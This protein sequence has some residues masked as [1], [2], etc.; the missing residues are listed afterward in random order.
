MIIEKTTTLVRKLLK[1]FLPLLII[2]ILILVVFYHNYLNSLI[3]K[4][5]I[6]DF[7]VK[8]TRI[9]NYKD[10]QHRLNTIHDETISCI[11]IIDT[12]AKVIVTDLLYDKNIDLIKQYIQLTLKSRDDKIYND[13]INEFLIKP[14]FKDN[15]ITSFVVADY[16][17]SLNKKLA[18]TNQTFI[19]I[20]LIVTLILFISIVFAIIFS[21][22][23]VNPIKE[24]IEGIK[25]ISEGDSSYRIHVSADDEI[26]ILENSFNEM[27]EKIDQ[28]QKDIE[29][30][31]KDLEDKVKREV[32]LN[33]QKDKKLLQQSRLAQMGEMLSMIAHQWRQPLAAISSSSS[34]I[35][36]KSQLN[37]LDE[38]TTLE[39]AEKISEYSQDLS[40][41]IDDFRDFFKPNREKTDTT[42]SKLIEGV[43]AIVEVSIINKNINIVKNLDSNDIFNTYPN[44]LKQVILNLIKNAEDILLEKKIEN[45]TI[46]IETS[47]RILRVSDNGGGIPEDIIDNI[48]NPYFSTKL[49]KNGTG[50]GL[51]MSKTIVEEHC[52]G[53][54]NVLNAK[55]GAIFSIEL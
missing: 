24:L 22:H 13:E 28:S 23:I 9:S 26:S 31:N 42:Y 29:H 14:I 39:L 25:I 40:A 55:E 1:F 3:T 41:T 43:L 51:Y 17:K 52:A 44:E 38:K 30:L 54:L 50:L 6:N 48:F 11:S 45:P 47:H 37:K 7:H 5:T 15:K 18:T 10:I 21:L 20:L 34:S 33:R 49:E 27:I 4:D 35:I 8:I 32:E 19:F 46:T 36:I 53:T 12:D 16:K 2:P